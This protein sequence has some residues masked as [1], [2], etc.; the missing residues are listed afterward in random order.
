M[1]SGASALPICA[2]DVLAHMIAI[3]QTARTVT[4]HRT[5]TG[6]LLLCAARMILCEDGFRRKVFRDYSLWP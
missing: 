4:A 5:T 2:Q 1:L 6:G 3:S